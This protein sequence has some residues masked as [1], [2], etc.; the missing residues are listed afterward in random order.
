MVI[1]LRTPKNT[2]MLVWELLIAMAILMTVFFPLNLSILNEQKVL[3]TGY[4]RSLAISLVDG[5]MEVLA[6]GEWKSYK[7]G[8]QV[9]PIKAS[10]VTNLPPGRFL[11]TVTNQAIRLEWKPDK[12]FHGGLVWR[13]AAVP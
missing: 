3:R 1:I 4:H 8:T 9:Y 5:E 2:G 12:P 11:L 6:A 10:A 7:L 13:E